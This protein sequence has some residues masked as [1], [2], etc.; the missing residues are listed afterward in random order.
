M[1]PVVEHRRDGCRARARAAPRATRASSSLAVE[2]Q[3]LGRRRVAADVGLDQPQLQRQG[4]QPLLRAVVQVALEPPALGVA[5]GD[6]P[7][8]RGLQL[9]EPR[10]RTRRGAARSRA[11]SRRRRAPPRP[12]RG[13]R[14]ATRRRRAR[15]TGGRR[16]RRGATERRPPA[17]R[18]RSPSAPAYGAAEQARDR[19]APCASA[20]C[21]A[22]PRRC[23]GRGTGRR[24]RRAPAASAAG[25]RGTRAGRSSSEQR[26]DPQQGLGA[27]ARRRGR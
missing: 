25:R 3:R 4:D 24:G 23:A 7:L 21:S 2:T 20:A 12:A 9:G 14:R 17:R 16:A 1:E 11:R 5:G 15:R 10:L 13:R 8:A 22:S 26:G 6:D 18:Q 27:L 19:R